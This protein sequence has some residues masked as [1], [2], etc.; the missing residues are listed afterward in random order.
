ML[1]AIAVGGRVD[2]GELGGVGGNGVNH[3]QGAEEKDAND[4]GGPELSEKVVHRGV[5]AVFPNDI[6]WLRWLKELHFLADNLMAFLWVLNIKSEVGRVIRFEGDEGCGGDSERLELLEE[7][8]DLRFLGP[9]LSEVL[10]GDETTAGSE[11]R[12]KLCVVEGEDDVGDL[13]VAVLFAYH[14]A[15]LLA[16]TVRLA[17]KILKRLLS[18]FCLLNPVIEVLLNLLLELHLECVGGR[19]FTVGMSLPLV[20]VFLLDVEFNGEVAGGHRSDIP[21]DHLD[22]A[23]LVLG[24][25]RDSES[26]GNENCSGDGKRNLAVLLIHSCSGLLARELHKEGRLLGVAKC[27]A[28]TVLEERCDTIEGEEVL[29]VADGRLE[30]CLDEI[31][32]GVAHVVGAVVHAGVLVGAQRVDAVVEEL[33]DRAVGAVKVKLTDLRRD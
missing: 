29:G 12:D 17:I 22:L 19:E 23:A 31:G 10:S 25:N 21:F 27:V 2:G 13:G 16:W 20:V 5:V 1:N 6:R 33:A 30:A 4:E 8:G 32:V 7:L 26:H 15:D 28:G 9:H 3:D 11:R 14:A 18:I 24:A